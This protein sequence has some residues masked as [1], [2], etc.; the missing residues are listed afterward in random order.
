MKRRVIIITGVVLLFGLLFVWY[1]RPTLEVLGVLAFGWLT[2]PARGLPRVTIAWDGVATGSVCLFLFIIGLHRT[3]RWFAGEVQK[4]RGAGVEAPRLWSIRWTA[5]L[6]TLIVTMFV[7]GLSA[8]G[9]VHQVGWLIAS[10]NSF[11][12]QKTR[13]WDIWGTSVDHLRFIGMASEVLVMDR[14]Q[15]SSGESRPKR[16][17]RQS[18]MTELLPGTNFVLSGR[19]DVE[20]PWNAPQNSALFKGVVPLFLNP[21]IRVHRS[22]EGY[23]LSHYAGNVH[24][25]DRDRVSQGAM[26]Q[27]AAHTILAGEVAEGFKPWGDPTNLRDPGLG[28]NQAPGGFGGPSGSGANLLFMDGSVQFF[29]NT[30]SPL[31]LRR[32]SRSSSE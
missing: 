7:A 9:V 13:L 21:D 3:L 1:G 6:V 28:V 22:P 10:R 4:A 12:E 31:V 16:E 11:V 5:A 32:L 18:W 29:S 19:L 8:T 20:H 15:A 14:E 24:V 17:V 23:A 30:T 27:D 25:L 26:R 2:Y